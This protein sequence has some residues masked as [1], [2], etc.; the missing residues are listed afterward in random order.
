[1][2]LY[3]GLKS[4]EITL[5]SKAEQQKLNQNWRALL[6]RRELGDTSYPEELNA[7]VAELHAN[8]KLYWQHFTDNKAIAKRY[9]SENKGVLISVDVPLSDI[10]RYFVLEFQNYSKR[11]H[12]FEIVYGVRN[13][14][15]SDHAKSWQL[16]STKC[17]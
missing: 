17:E 3:R 13:S 1:M 7:Q 12:N 14:D 8:S 11:K 9:A 15:L 5:L 16:T 2:K 4:Q 10:E 6:A